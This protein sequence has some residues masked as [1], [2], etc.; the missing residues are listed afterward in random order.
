MRFEVDKI[1]EFEVNR[2]GALE[3]VNLSENVNPN[4]LRKP[5]RLTIYSRLGDTEIITVRDNFLSA[6]AGKF[7]DSV[8]IEDGIEIS[9]Q[10]FADCVNITNVRWNDC[11]T[12]PNSCFYGC[13]SLKEIN[14]L[15]SVKHIDSAAF[16]K[17]SRLEHIDLPNGICDIGPYA[18]H[19]AGITS[20][21]W[22]ASCREVPN[23]CFALA[24]ALKEFKARGPLDSIENSAFEFTKVEEIDLSDSISCKVGDRNNVKII[25]PFYQ[26]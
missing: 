15:G 24:A 2:F 21:N 18:F 8:Y 10:A 9:E 23:H 6:E 17:C 26:L 7:V 12:I 5:R 20:I 4:R 13:T 11:E 1:F 19:R 22:P 3:E 25:Y 14:N 16:C